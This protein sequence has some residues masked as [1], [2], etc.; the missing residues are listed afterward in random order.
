MRPLAIVVL[1]LLGA[2]SS[3]WAR[4]RLLSATPV[5]GSTVAAAP[6]TVS[7]DFTEPV[8]PQSCSITVQDDADDHAVT[9]GGLLPAPDNPKRLSIALAALPPG[10][11]RVIW[12]AMATDTLATQGTYEFTVKP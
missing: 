1:L 2:G 10:T 9:N 5:P 4:A 6:A 12:H 11:Y 8:D 3:A 7:I